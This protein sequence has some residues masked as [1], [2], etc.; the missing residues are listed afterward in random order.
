MNTGRN[1]GEMNTS[2][3]SCYLCGKIDVNF[4][5]RGCRGILGEAVRGGVGW[6]WWLKSEA[7]LLSNIVI[8]LGLHGGDRSEPQVTAV[9]LLVVQRRFVT[10][11]ER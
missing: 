5:P 6:R 9:C 10:T 2:P 8:W 3:S 1:L 7:L 4:P 11:S